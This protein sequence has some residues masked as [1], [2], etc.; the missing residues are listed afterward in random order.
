VSKKKK[1]G[2]GGLK[3]MLFLAIVATL[4]TTIKIGAGTEAGQRI[5]GNREDRRVE[6][7][8]LAPRF[9]FAA[10]TMQITV[11]AIY[12]N[13][14][15]TSVDLTS[16][17][18]ISIDRQSATASKE[19]VVSSTP[20]QVSPGVDAIP[21][22]GAIDSYSDILTKDY[23]Y[24][25]ATEAGQP[26]TR[27]KVE[28]YYYGTE[29]D[30]NYIPMIDDIMGFELRDLPAKPLTIEAKTGFKAFARRAVN[31]PSAASSVTAIY[32][33]DMD[34]KTFR[35]A[36]PILAIRTGIMIQPET[37]VT[38]T[39]GFDDV[40]LLRF[41]DVEISSATATTAAQGL[42]PVRRVVYHYT[43]DVTE[44]SGEPIKIDVPTNFVDAPDDSAP[45]DAAPAD[46]IPVATP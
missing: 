25:S 34:M 40:G 3:F 27:Y 42:G 21:M 44:I 32:S 22:D 6:H 45:V 39:I 23:R 36:I 9:A 1:K 12:T 26:W 29:L 46:T 13:H 4:I 16:T 24:E 30:P 18:Q 41:A 15:G 11:S 20:S 28:P 19:I 7:T 31:N 37:P 8:S 38:V 43:L 35:R 17:K 33:Y 10:A 2:H 5:I 14:D